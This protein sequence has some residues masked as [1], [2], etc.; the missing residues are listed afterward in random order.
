MFTCLL[1]GLLGWTASPAPSVPSPA[2]AE[3][4]GG[5]EDALAGLR[6]AASPEEREAAARAL[7]AALGG[8]GDDP[9]ACLALGEAWLD[10]EKYQHALNAFSAVI[11]KDPGSVPAMLGRARALAGLA[12]LPKAVE[13]ARRATEAQP[14]DPRAWEAL[15]LVF[16]HEARLEPA[17]A[18][19]AFRQLLKLAPDH[20]GGNLGLARALAYEKKVKE[21]GEILRGW[22][23][24]HPEDVDAKLKLAESLYV[25][26]DYNAAEGLLA[27]VVARQPGRVEAERLLDS[28]R[29]RKA[30]HFWVP[31]VAVVLVPVVVFTIRRLRRGRVL[32]MDEGTEET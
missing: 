12:D 15:G 7:E 21:A 8:R 3:R 31:A 4:G 25:Q 18:E 22:L 10:L 24:R 29:T 13:W 27:E 32:K 6:R 17:R 9:E 30:I 20:R 1:F 23:A 5:V 19:A 16:L 2:L 11:L 26:D 28:I 14:D